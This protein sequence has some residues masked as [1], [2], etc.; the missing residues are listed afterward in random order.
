MAE[1]TKKE[2]EIQIR[3][4]FTK[5]HI[6]SFPKTGDIIE[7]KIIEKSA[8]SLF[9]DLGD[10]GIGAIP[11]EEFKESGQSLKELKTGDAIFAKIIDLKNDN[12]YIELSLKEA[13]KELNWAKLQEKMK[14]KEVIEVEISEA[15]RGGLVAKIYDIPA[16]MPA[17]QL[18][19]KHYPRVKDGDRE[20]ILEELKKF[21]GTKLK[22]QIIDINPSE[23]K[24]IISERAEAQEKL[25]G[26]LQKYKVGDVVEG[27]V[28]GIVNFGVFIKFPHDS[29]E[30]EKLEGLIHISELDY[31]LVKNPNDIVKIGEILKA[32]IVDIDTGKISLSLKALK[33]DPWKTIKEKY[34]K[35][36]IVSGRVLK[37]NPFGAFIELPENI[38]GLLHISEFGSE[39]KMKESMELNKEYQFKILM[40]DPEKHKIALGL[41]DSSPATNNQQLTTTND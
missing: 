24:L 4:I 33:E 35:G 29:P 25:K 9:V 11:D 39:K 1:E 14:S 21:V 12:G 13:G 23:N 37:F 17:S 6:V 34:K 28:G 41:T 26:I 19:L 20:K 5:S 32:E 27:E 38:Q 22:V 7:G 10:I 16:F 18:S 31:R 8:R 40:I 15:N 30:E 2:N 36:D 3:G